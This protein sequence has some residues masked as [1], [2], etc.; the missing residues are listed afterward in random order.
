MQIALE[1][2]E[3]KRRKEGK[4]G[5]GDFELRQKKGEG[6][7]EEELVKRFVVS[8]LSKCLVECLVR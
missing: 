8:L 7:S 3:V 1:E 2:E 4:E 6:C 5:R